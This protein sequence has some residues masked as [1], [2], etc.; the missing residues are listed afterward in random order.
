MKTRRLQKSK[1]DVEIVKIRTNASAGQRLIE[2]CV[3]I[4][5]SDPAGLSIASITRLAGVSRATFYTYWRG[6]PE[7]YAD[8][9]KVWEAPALPEDRLTSVATELAS[10]KTMRDAAHA[11]V[12]YYGNC[13]YRDMMAD[14]TMR[15]LANSAARKP[16]ISYA[17][18]DLVLTSYLEDI[19]TYPNVADLPVLVEYI[20]HF[21]EPPFITDKTIQRTEAQDRDAVLTHLLH[22]V[23]RGPGWRETRV[24]RP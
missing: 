11:I 21:F 23:F 10:A 12:Y 8:V 2:A 16:H 17:G 13:A 9:L 6:L 15:K 18:L 19:D 14:Y 3:S 7:F 5:G 20:M 1:P 22:S 24:D 4:A